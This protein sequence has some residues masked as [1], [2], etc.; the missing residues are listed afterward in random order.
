[1]GVHNPVVGYFEFLS[2][3]NTKTAPTHAPIPTKTFNRST[4]STDR[5]IAS[6]A[7]L[8]VLRCSSASQ[9]TRKVAHYPEPLHLVFPQILVIK[10]FQ[11]LAELIGGHPV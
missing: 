4:R 5:V 7:A 9:R 10:P 11:P 2:V 1:M 8:S 3:L 6:Y